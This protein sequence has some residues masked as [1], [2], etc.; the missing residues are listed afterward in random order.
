MT[1]IGVN[2][3]LIVVVFELAQ[4]AL[5]S[6]DLYL[7]MRLNINKGGMS[8]IVLSLD[9]IV[10]D[11]KDP[12][13]DRQEI[14]HHLMQADYILTCCTRLN[15]WS[16][17]QIELKCVHLQRNWQRKITGII[18]DALHYRIKQNQ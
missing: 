17:I 7:P 4:S 11:L 14:T 13:D 1:R 5:L 9:T 15:C 8:W 3:S 18:I 12:T 10:T 2:I 16:H 6:D